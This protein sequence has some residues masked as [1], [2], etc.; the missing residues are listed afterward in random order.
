VP[1]PYH[2]P[3]SIATGR[4]CRRAWAYAYLAGLRDPEVPWHEDM[5]AGL[6]EGVTA[7]QRSTALGKAMHAA[8]E[9][10]YRGE[11]V[12]WSTFPAQVFLSGAHLLPH[13]DRVHAVHVERAIGAA[14]MPA[15][16]SDHAPPTRLQVHGV[17]FAG[18]AD[19]LV[20][21]PAEFVRMRVDAPDGWLLVDYKSTASVARYAL[22][23]EALAADVQ[24]N[25]YALDAMTR[26]GLDE[27]PARWVYFETKRKRQAAPVD[28]LVTRKRA[29]EVLQPAAELARE[30]D[31]IVDVDEAPCNTDA[32]AD[33]G[34]CVYHVSVGGPCLARRSIGKSIAK[35]NKSMSPEMQKK[36]D[37][38]KAQQAGGAAPPPADETEG[39][40][41]TAEAPPATTAAKPARGRPAAKAK[42]PADGL[43]ATMHALAD[44]LTAA[45][46]AVADV[47]RRMAEALA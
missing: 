5:A 17:W 32:C 1:R 40:T 18:Y 38:L 7:R 44:E 12:E 8:A 41:E 25:L 21:A 36:L 14:P 45:E 3:S 11:T 39:A 35:G 10:W 2:S 33:Y 42:A 34:G 26:L 30:L 9:S 29:L 16:V 15:G 37:A 13:P 27:L 23:P 20:S 31:A 43:G 6:R 28:V 47:R 22:T 24:C 19:L 46:A 4:R